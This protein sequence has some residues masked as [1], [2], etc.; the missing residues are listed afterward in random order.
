MQEPIDVQIPKPTEIKKPKPQ[1]ISNDVISGGVF[2][3]TCEDLAAHLNERL[4]FH[5]GEN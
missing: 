1:Y 2:K 5:R 3:Q 4:S